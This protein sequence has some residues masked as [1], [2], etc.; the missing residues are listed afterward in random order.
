ML[1]HNIIPVKNNILLAFYIVLAISF[2]WFA[3]SYKIAA[4]A[5]QKKDITWWEPIQCK[6]VGWGDL[7]DLYLVF[8]LLEIHP[9]CP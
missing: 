8:F 2:V 6:N 3:V 5:Y 1:D 7:L 4:Y 9:V